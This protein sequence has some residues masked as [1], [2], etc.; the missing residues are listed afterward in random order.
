[1]IMAKKAECEV[2]ELWEKLGKLN[3]RVKSLEWGNELV[4]QQETL[5]SHS[6]KMEQLQ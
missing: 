4:G 5:S 2:V 3:V 6:L 1:M